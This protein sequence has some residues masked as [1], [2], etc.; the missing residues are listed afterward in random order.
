MYP[1]WK[2]IEAIVTP[3][4]ELVWDNTLTADQ[5]VKTFLPPAQAKLDA[6]NSPPKHPA[7]NWGAG[8][9]ALL[10]VAGGWYFG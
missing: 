9:A 4:L 6:L 10:A 2:E 5:A 7:L 1:N 3:K 8:V